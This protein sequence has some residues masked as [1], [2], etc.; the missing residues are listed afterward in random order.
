[1]IFFV[2]ILV[3]LILGAQ[4]LEVKILLIEQ[5]RKEKRITQAGLAKALGVTQ[6]A[7][8]QWEK[9]L[10]FPDTRI[11]IKLSEVLECTVDELLKGE[12][13]GKTRIP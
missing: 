5:K 9:G 6:R 13:D 12:Q 7:V 3:Y 1:M 8:S 2:L 4:I 10:N 11:L